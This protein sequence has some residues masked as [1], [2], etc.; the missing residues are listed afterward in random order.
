[1]KTKTKCE[2][3]NDLIMLMVSIAFGALM[4]WAIASAYS[5]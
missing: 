3:K 4:Y 1:M 2:L 5:V